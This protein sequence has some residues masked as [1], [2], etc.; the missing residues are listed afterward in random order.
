MDERQRACEDAI[1][2]Y[3]DDIL[4][5]NAY[6]SLATLTELAALYPKVNNSV[7]YLSSIGIEFSR[8]SQE[9]LNER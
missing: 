5:L 9:S 4:K 8:D 3:K 1:C 7:D 2:R 6:C